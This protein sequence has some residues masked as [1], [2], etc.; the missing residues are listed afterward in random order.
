ME[1]PGIF[2]RIVFAVLALA[3]AA[4]LLLAE[5]A[6]VVN[7]S[8]AWFLS[9]IGFC[10]VPLVLICF[11]LFITALFRRSRMAWLLLLS[12][13]IAVFFIGRTF[14][15][16]TPSATGQRGPSVMSYNVGLFANA[17]SGA[18]SRLDLADSVAAYIRSVGADVVCLQEFYLPNSVNEKR[19]LASRFPDYRADYY[20]LTGQNGT[21][22]CVTLSRYP[23]VRKGKI[24]FEGSTNMALYTDID[25]GGEVFRIYN[26]HLQS[27][28]MSI[29]FIFSSVRS[30]EK[31]EE[32]GRKFRRFILARAKQVD[33]L[34][35]DMK[36]CQVRS[37]AVGDFNEDLWG[38]GGG[39]IKYNGKWEKIDGGFAEGFPR[40]REEV[41]DDPLL[42]EEDKAFGGM[43]PRRTFVGPR[44]TGGVSD[45]L[46]VVFI[47][48]Y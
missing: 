3:F 14:R 43:K 21:A 27:Y 40:V 1:K 38:R 2:S 32:S 23:V 6:T 34:V 48:Y 28:N 29:P 10:F 20:T 13:V 25:A 7:P 41:F 4:A 24:P 12:L 22:G 18:S 8:R 11:L 39:T 36:E 17:A 42:L 33:S 19:W 37:F 44:Y 45:H 26:C 47:V 15:F 35:A 30:E 46:P 5:A 31:M 9:L 16:S